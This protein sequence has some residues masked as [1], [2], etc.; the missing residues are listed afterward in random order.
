MD[1]NSDVLGLI[2]DLLGDRATLLNRDIR[3]RYFRKNGIWIDFEMSNYNPHYYFPEIFY[4]YPIKI[5]ST[6]VRSWY[7]DFEERFKR[8]IGRCFEVDLEKFSRHLYENTIYIK[9]IRICDLQKFKKVKNPKIKFNLDEKTIPEIIKLGINGFGLN[10]FDVKHIGKLYELRNYEYTITSFIAIP[11]DL[12]NRVKGTNSQYI[13]TDVLYPNLKKIFVDGGGFTIDE[14]VKKRLPKLSHIELGDLEFLRIGCDLHG[15]TITSEYWGPY[16]DDIWEKLSHSGVKLKLDIGD[17]S[18]FNINEDILKFS[19]PTDIDIYFGNFPDRNTGPPLSKIIDF[20]RDI[21]MAFAFCADNEDVLPMIE[22]IILTDIDF[23]NKLVRM[24]VA[25]G[26]I[27]GGY[28]DYAIR[29]YRK[30]RLF[31]DFTDVVLEGENLKEYL[32]IRLSL[33]GRLY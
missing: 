25:E 30:N 28:I 31:L 23:G 26:D 22:E 8:V 33:L 12:A 4:T 21:D 9:Y 16:P 32:E 5:V 6:Y 20:Y 29:L 15:I 10:I 7:H 14:E 24:C 1:L 3:D 11:R 27:D 18:S 2:L 19:R 13:E 17:P